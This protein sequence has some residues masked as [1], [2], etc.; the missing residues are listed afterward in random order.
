MAIVDRN[1][2][3]VPNWYALKVY[4]G[5]ENV[6]K[7]NLE[8]TI[9]KFGLQ[10]RIF[11]IVIPMEDVLVEKRGKKVLVPKKTMPGY[12][13][14]RMIYGDDIWHAVTNTQYVNSFV[15]PRGRP[16]P[17]T[18]DEARK[19][20]LTGQAKANEVKIELDVNVGDMVEIIDGSLSS[21]VGTVK[22]VDAENQKVT[23]LVEMFGRV[24]EV[25]L[26]FNQIRV[27]NK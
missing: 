3:K 18:E 25:E 14:V 22:A 26:G 11:D 9:E 2:D 4:A 5:Y 21:F 27:S 23:V 12:M 6:A 7:Q 10:N 19:M 24:S 1:I 17:I 8:V 16:E 15:G 20:G 13:M